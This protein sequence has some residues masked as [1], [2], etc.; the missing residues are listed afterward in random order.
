MACETFY[1]SCGQ[2]FDE[3]QLLEIHQKKCLTIKE[4]K[5]IDHE[6]KENKPSRKH[7]NTIEIIE[8]KTAKADKLKC[9]KCGKKFRSNFHLQCHKV[10]HTGEM[11]F[12]CEVCNIPFTH[13]SNLKRHTKNIH[14]NIKPNRHECQE[15]GRKLASLWSLQRHKVVHTR[16]KPFSCQICSTPFTQKED[17]KKHIS[18]FHC[19]KEESDGLQEE[20]KLPRNDQRKGDSD[21]V[22][23]FYCSCGQDFDTRTFLEIHK[24]KCP[25]IKDIQLDKGPENNP[26]N[27]TINAN[28]RHKCHDCGKKFSSPLKLQRHK[29]VHTREK[30]ISCEICN[31]RYTE[32]LGLK[33]HILRFHTS[34]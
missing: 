13:Q 1:C 14:R 24:Q 31:T 21:S 7:Q 34:K 17:M 5:E 18:K 2:D 27:G 29:V 26:G 10:V 32:N 28:H 19:R 25:T 9:D 22:P 30:P 33:R 12:S 3:R 8:E 4:F 11:P 23:L 16:E 20:I 6:T 15:C